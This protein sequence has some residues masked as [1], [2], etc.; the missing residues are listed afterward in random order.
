MIHMILHFLVYWARRG[1]YISC[2]RYSIE[3]LLRG[4]S[5]EAVHLVVEGGNMMKKGWVVV[6]L[7]CCC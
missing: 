3:R 4:N 7:D 6:G 2:F 5:L 1:R